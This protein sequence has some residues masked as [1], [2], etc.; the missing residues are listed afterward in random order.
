MKKRFC[1]GQKVSE[2]PGLRAERRNFCGSFCWMRKGKKRK[3]FTE[4]MVPV[5]AEQEGEYVC[6]FYAQILCRRIRAGRSAFP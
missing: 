1:C 2:H 4:V 6:D 3:Q 5:D